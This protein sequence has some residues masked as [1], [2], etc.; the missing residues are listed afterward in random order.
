MTHEDIV[1][2]V[3]AVLAEEFEV[4]A[5]TLTPD[6][7]LKDTLSLDSLSL[8]DLVAIIQCT[9][10]IKIPVADLAKIKTLADLYAYIEDKTSGAGDGQ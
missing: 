3:N 7:N 5:S 6:S 10:K 1:Q 8:V 9:Y 2:K 4:D